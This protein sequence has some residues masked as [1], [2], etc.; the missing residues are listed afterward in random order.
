MKHKLDETNNHSSFLTPHSSLL[1]GYYGFGNLG[2]ELLL[3]ACIKILNEHGIGNEK[4]I[5]L[6]N[7]PEETQ[8]NFNVK[9][10]NR[11]KFLE[12][13]K[14]MRQSENFILGGGGLFQ[15]STSVKSCVYYWGIVRLAK[16]FGLKIYALGQ[17]VGSFSSKISEILTG[18]ALRLCELVQVRDKN[19]FDIAKDF[20]VKNLEPASDLVMTLKPLEFS[21]SNRD[22]ILVNL[23]P[24]KELE[25]FVKII[26]PHVKNSDYKKIGAAL[27]VED[28]KI[29]IE[30]QKILGLDEIKLIKNFDEA[31]KL[32][33]RASC[34]VGMRLHFGVLARIFKVKTALI[35]Y[36]IKVSE[37]ASQ[38]DI[39]VIIDK[40]QNPSMP[41]EIPDYYCDK[42]SL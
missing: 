18:D 36:D 35:P 25:K 31:E 11:W 19:S 5:V 23:R 4:I 33:S 24:H 28:E 15:D 38:S 20:N 12:V 10:M 17:S 40:W 34:A 2:D 22:L 1:L 30:N 37:F 13:V 42:I 3:K 32:F 21:N 16:L 9:S 29:L 7:N 27:S 6:S 41:S 26:A 39:P 8:K 14:A